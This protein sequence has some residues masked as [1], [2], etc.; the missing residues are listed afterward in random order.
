M[1]VILK[2][3]I[4][5]LGDIGEIVNVK[6]GY[7][8][9]FLLPSGAAEISTP[10]KAAEMKAM[11]EKERVKLEKESEEAQMLAEKISHTSCTIAMAAGEEEK[12]FGA[13]TATDVSKALAVEG[14]NI[15]KKKIVLEDPIK[16]LGIYNVVIKLAPNVETTLKLWV[17]KE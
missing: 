8:R 3:K 4:D 2:K 15:P 17:V 5:S 14:I 12:L 13:V 10:Q 6:D 7:A 11:K 1:L 16:K 9:N